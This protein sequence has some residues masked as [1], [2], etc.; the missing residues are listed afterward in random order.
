MIF[1]LLK[2]CLMKKDAAYVEV[3]GNA[4]YMG[5]EPNDPLLFNI[6][7]WILDL[8]EDDS[9]PYITAWLPSSWLYTDLLSNLE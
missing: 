9:I 1:N 6:A 8:T 4:N 7:L 5:K 3:V 2:V